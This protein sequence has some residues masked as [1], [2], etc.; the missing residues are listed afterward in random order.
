[1]PVPFRQQS[2]LNQHEVNAQLQA[3]SSMMCYKHDEP[4]SCSVETVVTFAAPV[5][6]QRFSD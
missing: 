4:F 3:H 5:Q 1:M 2:T 6:G